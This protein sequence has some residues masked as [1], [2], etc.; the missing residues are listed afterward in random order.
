M[1]AFRAGSEAATNADDLDLAGLESP[2]LGELD[3]DCGDA[4]S[5][6]GAHGLALLYDPNNRDGPDKQRWQGAGEDA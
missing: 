5:A 6:V 1:N 4:A 3:D 2:A